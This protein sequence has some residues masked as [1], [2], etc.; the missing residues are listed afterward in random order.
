MCSCPEAILIL[1]GF[2]LCKISK[3]TYC[4]YAGRRACILQFYYFFCTDVQNI[5]KD[6]GVKMG[7]IANNRAICGKSLTKNAMQPGS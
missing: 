2:V 7:Y 1:N 3:K 4:R 6:N 5:C